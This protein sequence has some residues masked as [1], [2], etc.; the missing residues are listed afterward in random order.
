[1]LLIVLRAAM[2]STL[3]HVQADT[4]KLSTSLKAQKSDVGKEYYGIT[5]DVVLSL[6]LTELKAHI[7]W[8]EGVRY[9]GDC[10]WLSYADISLSSFRASSSGTLSSMH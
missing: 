2:Y 3:C 5:F 7:V 8:E 1:M 9:L 4:S 6:G 10:S